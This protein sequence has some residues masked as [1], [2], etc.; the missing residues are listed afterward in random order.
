MSLFIGKT[1]SEYG[2][3]YEFK[4]AVNGDKFDSLSRNSIEE[5]YNDVHCML[6][7]EV[8]NLEKRKGRIKKAIREL[9]EFKP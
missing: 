3:S 9:E 4:A 1:I 5:A 2:N 6:T 7:Q 8:E